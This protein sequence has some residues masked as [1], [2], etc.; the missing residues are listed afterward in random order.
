MTGIEVRVD[1]EGWEDVRP[2]AAVAANVGSGPDIIISTMEDAHQYPDKLVDVSDLA[3]YLGDKYGGW[4]DSAKAYGMHD[5]QV[6]RRHD[7]RRR[8][9]AGLPRKRSEGRGLRRASRGT[10]AGF[11][12]LCQ[13]LKAKGTPAGFALGNATGDSSWTHLAGVGARRQAGRCQEQRRHQQPG[14]D[15]RARVLEAA[16]RDVHPGHAVVARPEQ[17]QGVPRRPAVPHCN[18][19]S[20]Y[21]AAKTSQDPKLQE[22]TKDIQHGYFPVGVDGKSRELNL[23]FPMMIFKYSK[24]PNAAKE[25]LRFMME[26]EQ[27]VPW[28]EAS[29]GYVC[30]PLAAYESSAFWTGGSQEDAVPR[31]HEEHDAQRL[32]GHDGLRVG[33]RAWLTSSSRTWWPKPHRD[34]RRRRKPRNVRRSGRSA[35][36]RSDI[37][38]NPATRSGAS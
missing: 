28:Q 32:R 23:V 20:I 12:K 24:Y 2:K 17:Q 16:L 11:L 15:R 9:R 22:M 13:A 21:Y 14:D 19:I 30:H 4:Y 18:G 7:G 33:G 6:G 38:G 8:Q 34:R 35:T 27:Y 29:I 26:K 37:C 31:L 1:A 10:C 36:T 25:Y 3:N 5:E